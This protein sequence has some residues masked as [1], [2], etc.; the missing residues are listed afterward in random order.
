MLAYVGAHWW[1]CL[2]ILFSWLWRWI[3]VKL[4]FRI[5]EI[6]SPTNISTAIY[7]KWNSSWNLKKF[8]NSERS[9]GSA[10]YQWGE[11]TAYHCLRCLVLQTGLE[12]GLGD[13]PRWRRQ[14]GQELG[15]KLRIRQ[16]TQGVNKSGC[17][18]AQ[19][20]R[21]KSRNKV[22]SN[23]MMKQRSQ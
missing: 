11:A 8:T 21:N 4:K 17:T 12:I 9:T 16:R 18:L 6:K 10:F 7:S 14:E 2:W 22:T 20:D 19:M 23:P 13:H 1:A 5:I 15:A 3:R